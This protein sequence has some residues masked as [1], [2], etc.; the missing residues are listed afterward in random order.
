MIKHLTYAQDAAA[1]VSPHMGL[2]PK[3]IMDGKPTFLRQDFLLI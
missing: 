1:F 3:G 2:F